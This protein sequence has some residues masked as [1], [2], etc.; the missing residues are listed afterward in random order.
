MQGSV[1]TVFGGAGAIGRQLVAALADRGARVRVAVPDIQ[2]AMFLK[3]LGNLGQIAPTPASVMVADSVASAL[4]GADYAVNLAGILTPSGKRTFT[5]VHEKGAETIAKLAA[6]KGV[7]ALVHVS[8]IGADPKGPADYASSK[9]K[10]EEKVKAAFPTA[11][12]LRPSVVFGPDDKFFNLFGSMAR[13]APALPY[14]TRDGYRPVKKEDSSIPGF[15]LA[16]SGGPKFQPVYV[17]DVVKAIVTCL[18]DPAKQGQTYELGGPTVYSMREIMELTVKTSKRSTMVVPLPFFV[19]RIQGAIL[20]LLPKP[21]ITSDQVTLMEKDNVVSGD[22]P[23]FAD[24]G[25]EPEAAEAILPSYMDRFG[26][27]HRFMILRGTG[28]S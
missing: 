7:K 9:G 5:A 4:D 13:L 1:V 25:I 8:A 3:P 21:L 10:G 27:M 14:F 22:L 15:D 16:G 2:K 17:G 12:I 28:T 19:A 20:G 18:E 23:T 24:L 6:E 26:A 11:A